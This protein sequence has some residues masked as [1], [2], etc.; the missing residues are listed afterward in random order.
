ME[1]HF[2]T[3]LDFTLKDVYKTYG[4]KQQITKATRIDPHTGKAKIIDH[5]WT[6]PEIK[7]K[8]TGTFLGLSIH[9]GVY[10]KL[11]KTFTSFALNSPIK[12]RN[13]KK[14]DKLNLMRISK[15]IWKIAT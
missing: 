4:L 3:G 8:S 9:F 7:L 11:P 12:Y 10:A 14:Y 13:F 5:I 15:K 2:T 6:N 1:V